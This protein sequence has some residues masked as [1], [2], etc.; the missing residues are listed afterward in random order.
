MEICAAILYKICLTFNSQ[1]FIYFLIG[2]AM[3]IEGEIFLLVAGSL[4]HFGLLD[5]WPLALTAVLGSWLSD[6]L[7]YEA[8][9]RWGEKFI[10]RCGRWFFITPTRFVKI[11]LLINGRGFWL[12]LFSKF[13]YGLNHLFLAAVGAA[14]LNFRRFLKYQ[15][16]VSALWALIFIFLGKF[17]S[18]GLMAARHDMKLLGWSMVGAIG[19][20]L[21]AE[22]FLGRLGWNFLEKFIGRSKKESLK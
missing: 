4:V 5:V 11:K 22:R 15:L 1:L 18:D 8:G 12:T 17:F 20:I 7:W 14:N 6:I 16:P 9:K 2:L 13:S 10:S 3:I 19:A 21:L